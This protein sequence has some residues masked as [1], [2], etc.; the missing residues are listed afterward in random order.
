MSSAPAILIDLVFIAAFLLA[1]VRGAKKG[2]ILTLCSLVAVIVAFI[3]A[4]FIADLLAPKVAQAIQP[5][6]EQIILEQLDEA[7]ENTQFIGVNGSVAQSSEEIALPNVLEVLRE[8][9]LY[10]NLMGGVEKALEEGAAATAASAASRVAT[11]LA[12][13]LA[14][15]ILFAVAFFLVLVAWFILSHAL[16]LVSKLPVLN[17]L[18]HSLGAVI[19]GIKGLILLYLLSWILCTLTGLIPQETAEETYLLS[20]LLSHGPLTLLGLS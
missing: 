3:G 19:G 11:A 17:S 16:D 15:G 10:Q 1:V 20:F 5:K 8:N 6:L 13:Q 2:F 14:R 18:N 12:G 7:L 9:Q 4:S